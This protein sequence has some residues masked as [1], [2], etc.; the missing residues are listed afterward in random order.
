MIAGI[1]VGAT[2]CIVILNDDYSYVDHLHMPTFLVGKN[3]HVNGAALSSFLQKYSLSHA[4]IERVNAMPSNGVRMGATSAF[5]FG[6]SAGVVEG[7]VLGLN[8]PFSL[9]LPATWKKNAR[10]LRKDKDATRSVVIP[11]Y[12]AIRD[13]DLIKKGQALADAILIA[14]CH[15]KPL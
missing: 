14:R 8:I 4:Y 9:V 15:V 6:H 7:V 13:L 5:N 2:G 1:D 3:R 12:P 11:L 10:L